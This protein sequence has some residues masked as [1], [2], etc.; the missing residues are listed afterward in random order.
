MHV[1]E[2]SE[3]VFSLLHFYIA[4]VQLS[5]AGRGL[6]GQAVLTVS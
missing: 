1:V 6:S 2:I 4:R 5:Y 3:Y